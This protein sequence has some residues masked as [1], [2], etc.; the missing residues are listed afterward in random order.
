MSDDYNKIG[1]YEVA[2]TEITFNPVEDLNSRQLEL[3]QSNAT[4][5]LYG[6]AAGGGKS[7]MLRYIAIIASLAIPGLQVYLFRRLSSDLARNHMDGAKCLPEML[8]SLVQAGQASINYGDGVVKFE[9]GSKIHLCHCQYEKDRFK[10]Q[11]AEIHLLLIDE[12]THFTESIYT[13]LRTRVRLGSLEI[14]EQYQKLFP[15]IICGTNPGGIGHNWVRNK[16]ID[17]ALEGEIWKVPIND[18]GMLRQFIPA[19]LTDNTHMAAVDP[20]YSDRLRG[21]KDEAMADALLTGNW[22]IVSGGA[23][24]DV[25]RKSVHVIPPFTVPKHWYINRSFDWGSSKPYA[26]IWW[27]ESN[28]EEVTLEDGTIKSWPAGTLFAIRE[29]YGCQ[30]GRPN[31]GTKELAA[32]IAAKVKNIDA[33]IESYR[34]DPLLHPNMPQPKRIVKPGPADSSI[35]N[36]ENGMS[37]AEDMKKAGCRWTKANKS[38]G[39]RV[40]GLELIRGRLKASTQEPMERPGL[41][42]FNHCLHLIRTLPVLPR[43]EYNPEDVDTASEDHLYDAVRYR[44][45][46][47]SE[48]TI[49]QEV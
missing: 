6:G 28:G 12:L 33:E 5:I 24:D 10:Y 9:N 41:F 11:G 19:K 35:F 17:Q 1:A 25:W 37:V 8:G 38:P 47:R 32:E 29:L 13:F 45:L 23:L 48:G 30:P 42:I 49:V 4:E 20:D 3:Y 21:E 26:V 18:G 27:A 39:S 34:P 43:D 46:R 31:E 22:D 40:Q 44:V 7:F 15:R 16:F 2:P 14:P 36:S